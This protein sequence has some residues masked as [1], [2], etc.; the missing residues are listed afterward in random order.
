MQ[1]ALR[2]IAIIA[3]V[4]H[5]KTTLVDKLLQQAGTFQAH[6]RI[7]ERVMDSNDIEKEPRHH[8]PGQEHG[9]R[10]RRGAHQHRRHPGPRRLR[11]RGRADP[12]DGGR[13]GAAGGR[14]RRPDAADAVRHP[15]GAGPRPE[16]DRAGQQGRPRRRPRPVGGEPDVRPLRPPRRGRVAAR[17]PGRLRLGAAGLGEPGPGLGQFGWPPR[18]RHAPA[19]RDHPQERSRAGRR[20]DVAAANGRG[21]AGL[22]ELRGAAGHRA[23]APRRDP[24]GHGR[25]GHGAERHDRGFQ[26][27][28]RV[29]LPGPEP[30]P[31]GGGLRGRDRAGHRHRRGVHRRDAGRQGAARGAAGPQDRRAHAEHELPGEHLAAGRPRRQVRHQPP[32]ARPPAEGTADQRRA[33]RGGHRRDG[34]VPRVG[35]GANC[36]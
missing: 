5:G 30:G 32:A 33:A 1:R 22:F 26:D 16:A 7:T 15:Q 11:R 9:G 36:T 20:P 29:R 8:D 13:R 24:P 19:V 27:H 2:N 6:E 10:F 3:H 14:G 21:R 28:R 34:R 23:P 25:R 12:L 35:A 31:D 17:L 18:H 4:D